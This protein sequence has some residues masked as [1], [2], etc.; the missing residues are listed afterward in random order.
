MASFIGPSKESAQLATMNEALNLIL[1][2]HAFFSVVAMIPVVQA[3][4]ASILT[5]QRDI[6]PPGG[7]YLPPN[8]HQYFRS[9]DI[10][11]GILIVLL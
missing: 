4:L 5:T 6:H 1:Q 8:L 7:W 2:L 3:E 9:G 10:E 11:R